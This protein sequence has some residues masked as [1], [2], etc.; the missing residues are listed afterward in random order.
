MDMEMAARDVG[1]GVH[2]SRVCT[3]LPCGETPS[4]YLYSEILHGCTAVRSLHA[5]EYLTLTSTPLVPMEV[6]TIIGRDTYNS[7]NSGGWELS[8]LLSSE[9][10]TWRPSGPTG[11]GG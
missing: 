4:P 10:G 1:F 3:R 2:Q 5:T 6:T 11:Q 7:N 8:V 9:H